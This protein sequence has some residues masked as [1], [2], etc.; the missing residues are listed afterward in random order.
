MSLQ[1]KSGDQKVGAGLKARMNHPLEEKEELPSVRLW[2]ER[3]QWD[4]F[5]KNLTS[6]LKDELFSVVALPSCEE[7]KKLERTPVFK[8]GFHC[9]SFVRADYLPGAASFHEY[10]E[11]KDVSYEFTVWF[12]DSQFRD[13]AAS[14]IPLFKAAARGS[15]G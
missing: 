12:A 1:E 9:A 11:R 4:S 13:Y 3:N 10:L 2:K 6:N 14:L 5:N 8:H 7:Q 15:G